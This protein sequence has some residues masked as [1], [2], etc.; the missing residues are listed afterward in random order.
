[1]EAVYDQ[2]MRYELR[3]FTLLIRL[4]TNTV[5]KCGVKFANVS[6][7]GASGVLRLVGVSLRYT[8]MN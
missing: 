5:A 8:L 3:V 6:F 1:M 2:L 4:W 7:T